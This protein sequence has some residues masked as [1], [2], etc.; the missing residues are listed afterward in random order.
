MVKPCCGFVLPVGVLAGGRDE[1]VPPAKE[2][3]P[4]ARRDEARLLPA[5]PWWLFLTGGA[6]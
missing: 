3:P 2:V 4:R 6:L 5:L 1:A